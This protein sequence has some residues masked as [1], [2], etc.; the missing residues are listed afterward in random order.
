MKTVLIS[1]KV[2]L[3]FTVLT[4]LLYPLAVTG[5]SQLAFPNKANG[6]LIYVKNQVVGSELIGQQF[7]GDIYFQS[8][9][10]ANSYNTLPSGGTNLGLTSKNLVE[11]VEERRMKFVA[12]NKLLNLVD[13]PSE[14]LFASG[15]GLDPHISQESALL[16]VDRIAESR[17]FSDLKKNKLKELVDNLTE[18][19]T[20]LFLGEKRINVLILNL[21]ID[22]IK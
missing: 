20:F 3:F 16:Q 12:S 11:K 15:S 22:D 14:M 10:S 18:Q 21:R 13:V 5:I 7:V 4:G 8:R 6:S 17:G 1:L 19:P 9:P 2:L